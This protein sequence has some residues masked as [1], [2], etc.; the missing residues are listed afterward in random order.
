[1]QEFGSTDCDDDDRIAIAYAV[2]AMDGAAIDAI[3]SAQ[4]LGEGWSAD[5]R[6][7]RSAA[8]HLAAGRHDEAS[9][10]LRGVRLASPFRAVKAFLRGLGA[11]YCGDDAAAVRA[12]TSVPPGSVLDPAVGAVL[13]ALGAPD[14]AYGSTRGSNP[15]EFSEGRAAAEVSA[16]LES[17]RANAALRAIAAVPAMR[18][19]LRNALAVL[20]AVALTDDGHD[21]RAVLQR[22]ARALPGPAN[23][24][25]WARL[26]G[27]LA[28]HEAHDDCAFS[29]FGTYLEDLDDLTRR[30]HE[31]GCSE[32]LVA[33]VCLQL[34]DLAPPAGSIAGAFPDF[35]DAFGAD[36]GLIDELM[37][38]EFD[39][40]SAAERRAIFDEMASQLGESLGPVG[41]LGP[42]PRLAY[43]V[44]ARDAAPSR[45]E[46]HRRLI[47]DLHESEDRAE[48]RA[49]IEAMLEALPEDV[50]ALAVAADAATRRGAFDKAAGY[51]RRWRVLSPVDRRI[52]ERH[53]ALLLAKAED[54]ARKRSWGPAEKAVSDV[55]GELWPYDHA[56][57]RRAQATAHV[58][59][60]ISGRAPLSGAS[61]GP[62][63][64]S[65]AAAR[66]EALDR[67]FPQR[68]RTSKHMTTAAELAMGWADEISDA[69]SLTELETALAPPKR[70]ARAASAVAEKAITLGVTTLDRGDDV[71]RLAADCTSDEI[72][73]LLCEAGGE[74]FPTHAGL[75][76]ERY[77]TAAE[78][79]LPSS[80]FARFEEDITRA[81]PTH[82][83][84][85]SD[86]C[87]AVATY[88]GNQPAPAERGAEIEAPL[89]RQT[90]LFP[91]DDAT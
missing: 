38:P 57:H 51:L 73:L 5:A 62:P 49:A 29:A 37:P 18:P 16:A 66:L 70:L 24:P 32:A 7:C 71:F 11:Y 26:D 64:W 13:D 15:F 72:R 86:V 8:E 69:P 41:Q 84:S 52:P 3:G 89:H 9:A 80:Y 25:R 1:M 53:A 85:L 44:R 21:H 67:L 27:L 50:E 12:L 59:A 90:S 78:C 40:L 56:I 82:G 60:R 75:L 48:H 79:E 91:E 87:E 35:L 6:S 31:G 39:D 20:V 22:V 63:S 14:A 46:A 81:E 76:R 65:D 68:K 45:M 23:D 17:G 30:G 42:D 28:L 43:L 54:R 47:A 58:L 4:A 88:L 33:S 2:L 61:D 55:L 36:S 10:A 77:L 74:R 83:A 19:E 34:A